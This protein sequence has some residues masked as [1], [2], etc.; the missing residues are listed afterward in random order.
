[1][2]SKGVELSQHLYADLNHNLLFAAVQGNHINTVQ[3]TL[4]NSW[5]N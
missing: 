3:S 1:M 2:K 5:L 4:V